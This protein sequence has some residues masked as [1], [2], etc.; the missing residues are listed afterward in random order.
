MLFKGWGL[1]W[2]LVCPLEDGTELTQG[3]WQLPRGQGWGP[4]HR[5]PVFALCEAARPGSAKAAGGSVGRSLPQSL[6]DSP[7]SGVHREP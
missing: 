5:L 3:L 1:L 2:N 7:S 4:A 6:I